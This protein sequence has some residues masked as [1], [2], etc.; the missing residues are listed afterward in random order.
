MFIPRAVLPSVD[1]AGAL[2]EER[3][4][5]EKFFN[6]WNIIMEHNIV[7]CRSV[8]SCSIQLVA[9]SSLVSAGAEGETTSLKVRKQTKKA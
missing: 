9:F 8:Q 5:Q 7:L 4:W 1:D 3:F 2:T 6:I